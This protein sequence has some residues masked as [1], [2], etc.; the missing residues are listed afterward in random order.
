MHFSKYAPSQDRLRRGS[1]QFA[2][3]AEGKAGIG[4]RIFPMAPRRGIQ[5]AAL[6]GSLAS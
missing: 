1:Q 6:L 4:S 5:A 3:E 2:V